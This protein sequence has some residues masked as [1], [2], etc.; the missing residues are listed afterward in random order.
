MEKRP[1]IK[2]LYN[3]QKGFTLIEVIFTMAIFA[4]GIL[5]VTS[6]MFSATRNNTKGNIM[7]Q[8]TM[9][10]RDKIEDL[11]RV[12]DVATLADGVE[13]NINDQGNPGGIYTRIWTITPTGLPNCRQIDVTVSWTREGRTRSVALTTLTK[14]S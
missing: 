3:E 12:S 13:T 11:K 1:K 9:L 2:A 5:A 14:G 7:T 4:I 8:A 6:L 10:A